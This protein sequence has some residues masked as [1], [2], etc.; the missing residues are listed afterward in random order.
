MD[1]LE[2]R[3]RFADELRSVLGSKETAIECIEAS[4]FESIDDLTHGFEEDPEGAAR[5]EATYWTE[6]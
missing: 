3:I 1:E 6:K 4:S 2:W 5:E